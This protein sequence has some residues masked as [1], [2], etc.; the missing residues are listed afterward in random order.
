[1]AGKDFGGRMNVRL[2]S[3]RMLALRGTFSVSSGS[4][5][6]EATTNQDASMDRVFTPRSPSAVITFRDDV[7]ADDLLLAPRQNIVINE[8]HTGV[9]HHFIDAVFTGTHEANRING[10]ASGVT[11]VGETYR[12]TGG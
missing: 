4:A 1:M 8:E 2:S 7:D 6:S 9:T 12:K 5:S 10:E 3:G 11:I